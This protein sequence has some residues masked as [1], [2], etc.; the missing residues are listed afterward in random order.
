[1]RNQSAEYANDQEH[2]Q[3]KKALLRHWK[4][5]ALYYAT[6]YVEYYHILQAEFPCL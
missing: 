3:A 2:T 5:H 1:M 4:Q 6:K